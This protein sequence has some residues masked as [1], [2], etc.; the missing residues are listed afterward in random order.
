LRLLGSIKKPFR[1]PE[2][3]GMV[4]RVLGMTR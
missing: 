1:M 2:L 4:E 3:F